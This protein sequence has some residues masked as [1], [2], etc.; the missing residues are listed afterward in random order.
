MEEVSGVIVGFLGIVLAI[1]SLLFFVALFY[2][3]GFIA[4]IVVGA[5]V[6][7]EETSLQKVQD[8]ILKIIIGEV[9]V[10]IVV[11]IAHEAKVN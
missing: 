8:A 2:I 3:V 10:M 4:S 9:I 5:G 11:W 7:D 1:S 6:Y